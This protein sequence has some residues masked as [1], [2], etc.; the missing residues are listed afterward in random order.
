MKNILIATDFSSASVN[1]GKYAVQLATHFA[2]KLFLFNSYVPPV[3][4]PE[5]YLIFDTENPAGDA[6]QQLDKEEK[7]INSEGFTVVE[8]TIGEGRPAEAIASEATRLKADVVVCGMKGSGKAIRKLFGSTVTALTKNAEFPLLVIPEDMDFRAPANILLGGHSRAKS[9]S[10]DV[11][12]LSDIASAFNSRLYIVSIVVEDD[13][14]AIGLNERYLEFTNQ[15][16]TM[17]PSFEMLPGNEIASE[18]NGYVNKTG[19]NMIV[20][21]PQQH[22]F[23]ERI[24]LGSVTTDMTF[25]SKIPVL[26]LPGAHGL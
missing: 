15:L 18:L 22:G 19:I 3:Q 24:F 13:E 1:A 11:R 26:I 12:I 8:K 4:I 25:L 6:M 20:L 21:M 5:S 7:I 10:H 9:Y 17:N 16:K 2:A 14:N 23:L